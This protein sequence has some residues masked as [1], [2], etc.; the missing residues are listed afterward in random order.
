MEPIVE[1]VPLSKALGRVIYKDIISQ[2]NIP[3]FRRSSV[4][5]YA[6]KSKET[7]GASESIPAMFQ[8]KGEVRMGEE[9]KIRLDFPGSC[10]Y[11]PTGGML[12]VEADCVVMIFYPNWQ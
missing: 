1:K 11:V 10:V 7:V 12:P 8:L 3:G 9:G 2:E 5:G 4:D 6:V